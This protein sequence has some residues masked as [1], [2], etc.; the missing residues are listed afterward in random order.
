MKVAKE[1]DFPVE[2]DL[3]L[4]IVALTDDIEEISILANKDG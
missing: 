3:D 4:N 2:V 1:E